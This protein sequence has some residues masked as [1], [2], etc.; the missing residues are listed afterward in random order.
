[1]L[2][3]FDTL[4]QHSGRR[5]WCVLA[6]ALATGLGAH[7]GSAASAKT[8]QSAIGEC[9]A[10]HRGAVQEYLSHG[11]ARS[12]GP[13]GTVATG[14]IED[15][16]LGRRYRLA[17]DQ[18][19]TVL[20]T[21]LAGGGVLRQRI[22][23]R[24]GG[25]N[26][27]T[28][29]VGEALHPLTGQ[30]TGRLYFAPL[31]S[32][33]SGLHL[34]P[35]ALYSDDRSIGL[36]LTGNCLGCHTLTALATLPGAARRQ[37]GR[38]EEP[39]AG[40][41]FPAHQLGGDAFAHLQPIG[42]AGC[43]GDTQA[44]LAAMT[45]EPPAGDIAIARLGALSPG[46]QR[47]RCAL[48]HLQGDARLD[49][50]QGRIDH[51]Q[52]LAGQIP[53]LVPAQ[54]KE[55][56]FRFV[57]QLERLALAACF[58]A[59]QAMTCTTC[60]R[61]HRAVRAQGLDDFNARCQTCHDPGPAHTSLSVEA[62]TGRP[63][64]S[65]AGCVDCHM[66]RSQPF[67]L[68]NIQ[69][70]DHDIRRYLTPPQRQPTHRAFADPQG[71]LRL[72]DDGRLAG[73]L[74]SEAGQKWQ[75]AVLA[76]GE[77]SRGRFT[78]A[79]QKFD[80]LPA[81]GSEAARGTPLPAELAPIQTLSA[82]HHSRALTLMV[83][84]RLDEARAAFDDALALDSLDPDALLGRARLSLDRL[85]LP[86]LLQDT[87]TLIDH[88][89]NAEQPWDLRLTLAERLSRPDL[90]KAALEQTTA[91]WPNNAQNWYKLGMFY[92]QAGQTEAAAR[93]LETAKRLDPALGS[94]K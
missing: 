37:T 32:T 45:A 4:Q 57:G 53:V 63:A 31:E 6:L 80:R 84:G 56:D 18:E 34:A 12:I 26:F 19:Q 47:D 51:E 72:Y 77:V 39:P 85:D 89:P 67:D 9:A 55:D 36:P 75:N 61:P 58:R 22:V 90:A 29:W 64:R 24:I 60:H 93:A 16:Q 11:M 5:P 87:Q 92:Q 52:P 14:T 59:T 28:S 30:P 25:D 83:N 73:A 48:C 49:L 68:P 79:Q 40:T 50:V 38:P 13:A 62:A 1:M 78:A 20:T 86:T 91:L 3:L 81:P 2:G 69:S 82:W 70:A 33:P 7:P 94:A 42:C 76:L 27:A 71:E 65:A 10:C 8:T 41:L 66:R 88:Y 54:P 15:R 21:T 44:H 43:H 35:F 23:G 46:A 74:A 17:R